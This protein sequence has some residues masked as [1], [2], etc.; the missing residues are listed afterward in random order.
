M[1]KRHTIVSS[2]W[3]LSLLALPMSLLPNR[4]LLGVLFIWFLFRHRI[5]ALSIPRFRLLLLSAVLV[6]A[7]SMVSNEVLS[8]ELLLALSIVSQGMFFV[9]ANP[10]RPHFKKGFHSALIIVLFTLFLAAI[11]PV[12]QLGPSAFFSQDQWWNLWHYE[13]FTG[14]L[15]LH[16]TYLSLF[17]LIGVNMILFGDES[18][19]LAGKWTR[20]GVILMIVYLIGLW[21]VSSKIALL[22]LVFL[23]LTYWLRTIVGSS[24]RRTLISGLMLLFLITLPFASPSVRYR[25]TN[26][27]KSA[28]QPLPATET[29]RLTERRALW[30]AAFIE[31]DRHPMAGTSFRGLDSRDVIYPKAK[32]LYPAL[33][34]PM[35]AH[36][37]YIEG[38]LRYG[39]LFGVIL[40]VSSIFGMF[41]AYRENSLEFFGFVLVCVLVSMTES[42]LF[43]EQGLALTSLMVF[44]YL[45][46]KN[47][48]G[49]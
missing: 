27:L 47:G 46:Q 2:L 22:A 20:N 44:F 41:K 42:F 33:E 45:L 3:V 17:L 32:F 37:N 19:T 15:S 6:F 29:N 34:T 43:R 1:E 5:A 38:G 36:N 21:L 18:P 31:I 8:K 40:I 13:S 12:F 10:N 4:I 23:L 24:T 30:T 35:N 14:A 16:P 28:M 9:V 25:L 11:I 49:I 39:I 26:E 7:L 48:R